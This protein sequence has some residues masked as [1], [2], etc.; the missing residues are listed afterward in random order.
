MNEF[1]ISLGFNYIE[2]SIESLF[3]CRLLRIL[4]EKRGVYGNHWI[5]PRS[6][7]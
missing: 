2:Q 4:W 7:R 5:L 6:K 1:R 3:V